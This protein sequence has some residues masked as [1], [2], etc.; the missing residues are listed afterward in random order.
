MCRKFLNFPKEKTENLVSSKLGLIS[1]SQKI[2][3]IFFS[4]KFP[5]FEGSILFLYIYAR[6]GNRRYL[7]KHVSSTLPLQYDAVQQKQRDN[8]RPIPKSGLDVEQCK[9]KSL[10]H[11]KELICTRLKQKSSY[12]NWLLHNRN[13]SSGNDASAYQRAD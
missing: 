4:V 12:W 10:R 3:I 1:K 11:T 7:C 2:D 9:V 6:Q 8:F 5:L 13:I